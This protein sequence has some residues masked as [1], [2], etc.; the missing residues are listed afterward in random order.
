M[1][2]NSD[3][4]TSLLGFITDT[5]RMRMSHIYQP[6]MLMTLLRNGGKASVE[7]IAKDFLVRDPSQIEYYSQITKVMPGRV[8]G[9]NHGIVHKLNNEYLLKGYETLS[10]YEIEELVQAC[11]A[12]LDEY[13]EN[14]GQAI[15]NHRRKSAGYIPGTLRYDILKKAQ[16]R[17]ELCGISAEEKALE[18]D[19]IIPRNKGGSDDT[20]NLQSLCY[21]CNAMK[22]DRDDTDF[23]KVRESYQQREEGCLF[24]E[25]SEDRIIAAN[26]LAYA[27]RDGFPVTELHTLVIP[28]RHVASYFELGRPEINACNELLESAKQDIQ[29]SDD[30]VKGFN[31]GINVGE[32]AG[33]TIFHCHI[34][35]IPRRSGDTENPRGGVRGVIPERQSY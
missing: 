25:I 3:I 13:L 31:V 32:E 6:V 9:K 22:R 4:F 28:K 16:F 8:L 23:R 21:S 30:L 29:K 7:Q 14:R 11:Q 10:Q 1:D 19:H 18:V 15:F 17:C 12:R 35:L 20:S 26:E 2:K 5:R 27:I 34:H 33:Q 24:C